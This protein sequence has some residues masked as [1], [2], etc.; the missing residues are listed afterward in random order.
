[1]DVL[2]FTSFHVSRETY[3]YIENSCEY[4]IEKESPQTL[5]VFQFIAS[6]VLYQKLLFESL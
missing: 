2:I 3:F 4:E 5:V 1:M 6:I